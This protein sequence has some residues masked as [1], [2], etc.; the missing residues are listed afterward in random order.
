M[1]FEIMGNREQPRK[2]GL[3]AIGNPGFISDFASFCGRY[4]W[5][6]AMV[7]LAGVAILVNIRSTRTLVKHLQVRR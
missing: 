7:L 2:T 3:G 4:P 6:T 5:Q 1:A